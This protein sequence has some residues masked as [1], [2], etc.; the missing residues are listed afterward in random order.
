MQFPF[1]AVVC[2]TRNTMDARLA[3]QSKNRNM[4]C[5]YKKNTMPA[6]ESILFDEL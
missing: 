3:M 1:E 6:I 4:Q 5:M 2:N